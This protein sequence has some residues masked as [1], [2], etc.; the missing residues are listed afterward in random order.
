M[1][2]QLAIQFQE[3][4]FRYGD[5]Q[6]LKQVSF[7]VLTGELFSLL[8]PN[9]SGK[10]TL[11][12]LLSTLIAPQQGKLQVYGND[13]Q[14]AADV[15]RH[16]LGVVFQ[17]PGLDGK[18]TAYENLAVQAVLY[19]VSKADVP[20]RVNEVSE[21]LG[22]ADR[23]QD[24]VDE[25]SGGL[26]RR[27]E[28]A[29]S[30]LHRPRLLIMDEPTTGLDPSARSDVWNYVRQL[31]QSTGMT[32]F[33][34]THL[35]EEADRADRIAILNEGELVALDQPDALRSELGGDIITIMSQTPDQLIRLLEV[36]MQLQAQ[37]ID[38]MIRISGETDVG[39]VSTL[40]EKYKDQIQQISVGKPSLEDVFITRTGHRFWGA[41]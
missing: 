34:T 35:L 21:Q 10:T 24:K 28:L 32:V 20:A 40:H 37:L 29:K 33:M 5:R 7:D 25:L 6:A 2:D 30:L 4:C 3:L 12:R 13:V 19:G 1:S 8:G 15:V 23:L 18:L 9:G 27:I 16:D 31:Q 22:V 17:A 41:S 36:D 11:F 26:R 39:L 38:G 14:T